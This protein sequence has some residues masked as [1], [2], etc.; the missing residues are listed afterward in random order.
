MWDDLQ[1]K[2]MRQCSM[3]IKEGFLYMLLDLSNEARHG[4]R[5]AISNAIRKKVQVD[6]NR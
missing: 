1:M 3:I 2:G 4:W 6:C 5:M